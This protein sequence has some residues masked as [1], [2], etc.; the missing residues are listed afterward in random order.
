MI[1]IAICDDEIEIVTEL[2]FKIDNIMKSIGEEAKIYQFTNSNEMLTSHVKFNLIF[3][4]YIFSLY[5]IFYNFL[6]L[7]AFFGNISL[8]YI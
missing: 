6:Y 2:S 4:I 5:D 3:L 7:I 1:R 8:N